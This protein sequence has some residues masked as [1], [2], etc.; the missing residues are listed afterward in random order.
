[1]FFKLKAYEMK[2][3]LLDSIGNFTMLKI[4]VLQ[5]HRIL[6][7]DHFEDFYKENISISEQID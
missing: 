3:I 6:Q 1:M 2:M 4:I 5:F 7:Y